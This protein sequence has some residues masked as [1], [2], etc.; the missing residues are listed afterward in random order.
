MARAITKKNYESEVLKSNLPVIID[1]YASWCGPCTF[2]KPIFTQLEQEFENRILFATL[3]VE[4]DRELSIELGISSIPAF[5][6]FNNG[7]MVGKEIGTMSY[8]EF[9][10]KIKK[11]LNQ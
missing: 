5:L 3:N 9:L 2:M 11:H 7:V 1:V 4:E 6:F 10:E 8:E